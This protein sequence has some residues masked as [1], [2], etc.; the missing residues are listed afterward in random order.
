MGHSQSS[1][2]VLDE[3]PYTFRLSPAS[4]SQPD[5]TGSFTVTEGEEDLIDSM[6]LSC[7][8]D[9]WNFS[10]SALALSPP[11]DRCTN[12]GTQ[13]TDGPTKKTQPV[14]STENSPSVT[15]SPVPLQLASSSTSLSSS[16]EKMITSGECR[17]QGVWV[18]ERCTHR[19]RH[20]TAGRSTSI[21][22]SPPPAPRF[23]RRRYRGEAIVLLERPPENMERCFFT[24]L[25]PPFQHH[26]PHDHVIPEEE[27]EEEEEEDDRENQL[28][29]GR[30]RVDEK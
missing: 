12:D 26:H 10:S 21:P 2:G 9:N 30:V 29:D 24:P 15:L 16:L 14:T 20:E 8:C 4:P 7:E 28:S 18:D 25:V 1:S 3:S 6:L 11:N 17:G 27:E 13:S 22:L 19:L 5:L 23:R